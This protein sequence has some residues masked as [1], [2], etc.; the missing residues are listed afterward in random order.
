MKKILFALSLAL[1]LVLSNIVLADTFYID[2][3]TPEEYQ[4]N[5]L[6]GTINVPHNQIL[7]GMSKHNIKKE[8]KIILFCRSGKRADIALTNLKI[9]GYKDVTNIGGFEDAKTVLKK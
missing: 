2:V 1:S 9:A 7:S 6:E 4:E 3:R 8:D 5:S